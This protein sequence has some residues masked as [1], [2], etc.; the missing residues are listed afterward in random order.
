[1]KGE[2]K[3]AKLYVAADLSR[4]QRCAWC[5]SMESDGWR[6]RFCSR[7]CEIASSRNGGIG[8]SPV[9]VLVMIPL[10]VVGKYQSLGIMIL[11]STA[12]FGM[13]SI[14]VLAGKVTPK[15]SRKQLLTVRDVYLRGLLSVAE[16]PNCDGRIDLSHVGEDGVY[17]CDYC[18]S[19]GIVE[20]QHRKRSRSWR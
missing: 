15:Q 19:E 6:G 9:S 12:S 4:V 13:V 5:G 20:I 11:F 18:G 2:Q 16:C 3:G 14:S 1:M 10:W 7:T 8:F 17:Q